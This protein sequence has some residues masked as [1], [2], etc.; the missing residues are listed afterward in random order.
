L[1]SSFS[2]NLWSRA[3]STLRIFPFSG[4]IAWKL[5]SRYLA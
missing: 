4:R 2:S 5:L 1:I 3:F